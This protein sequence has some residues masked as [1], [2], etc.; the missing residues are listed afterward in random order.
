MWEVTAENEKALDKYEG[1]PHC[2]HKKEIPVILNEVGT[3]RRIPVMA[4]VYALPV[5][6][7]IGAPTNEYIEKC[8]RGYRTFGFDETTLDTAL[9]LSNKG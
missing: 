2:Y 4:F 9:K 3:N 7:E 1:C 5:D 6:R 8:R